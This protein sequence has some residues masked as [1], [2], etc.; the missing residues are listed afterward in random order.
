MLA[1]WKEN[2]GVVKFIIGLLLFGNS[3]LFMMYIIT[4]NDYEKAAFHL[5]SVVLVYLIAHDRG[6]K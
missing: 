5:V 3:L 2:R 6:L 1:W 4:F